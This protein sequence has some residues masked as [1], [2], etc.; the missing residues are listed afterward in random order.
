[1]KDRF[2]TVPRGDLAAAI[3]R[4]IE[5]RIETLFGN[6]ISAIDERATGVL[7]SFEHGAPREFDLVIGA[8]GL[9]STVRDLVFGP[10]RQFEKQLGYRVAVIEVEG[11]RPRD[12]LVFV[13]YTTPGRQ[14][15]LS[16]TRRPDDVF[17]PLRQREDDQPRAAR[18]KGTKVPSASGFR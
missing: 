3:F 9:H 14:V 7:V 11:Y 6:S 12:E 17:L 1:M 18:C 2:T 16:S 5:N 4:T 13:T 10:E 8:D 15:A